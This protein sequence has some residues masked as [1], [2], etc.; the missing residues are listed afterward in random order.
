MRSHRRNALAVRSP[1]S[2]LGCVDTDT[3]LYPITGRQVR[4]ARERRAASERWHDACTKTCS[5]RV[6]TYPAADALE[7]RNCHRGCH[8]VRET[9]SLGK[10]PW[11]AA[12]RV[13]MM[14]DCGG[15]FR[16][17]SG[18]G[19]SVRWMLAGNVGMEGRDR[20]S[21]AER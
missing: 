15:R 21:P 6:T 13:D 18:C 2:L 4:L 1:S 16:V 8:R 14:W 19:K 10:G 11:E 20:A 5:N 12:K 17:A 3:F 9:Q 7:R